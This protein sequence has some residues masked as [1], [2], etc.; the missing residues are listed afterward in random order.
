M[1]ALVASEKNL[2]DT[3]IKGKGFKAQT[4]SGAVMT[5]SEERGNL[6]KSVKQFSGTCWV[7]YAVIP[8]FASY[9]AVWAHFTPAPLRH[10]LKDAK[11]QLLKEVKG[12]NKK[13]GKDGA[14]EHPVFECKLEGGLDDHESVYLFLG[15]LFRMKKAQP[16]WWFRRTMWFVRIEDTDREYPEAVDEAIHKLREDGTVTMT[17]D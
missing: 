2:I 9:V 12:F 8:K 11:V 13:A 17:K 16:T 4:T 1:I 5:A 15:V 3:T 14:V 7:D 6:N 10:Q